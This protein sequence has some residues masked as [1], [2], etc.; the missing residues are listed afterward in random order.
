[1]RSNEKSSCARSFSL[2]CAGI[3]ASGWLWAECGADCHGFNHHQLYGWDSV[4]LHVLRLHCDRGAQ[5]RREYL[6]SGNAGGDGHDSGHG[7]G[8]QRGFELDGEHHHGSHL[9][10]VSGDSSESAHEFESRGQL[11]KISSAQS[12]ERIFSDEEICDLLERAA[13]LG[14]SLDKGSELEQL[15]I[16][17]L[18]KLISLRQ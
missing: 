9:Q 16:C 4:A 8:S 5:W 3:R 6:H 1:M 18:E 7:H 14:F 2:L 11:K 17:E 15:S 12:R 13:A 10:R